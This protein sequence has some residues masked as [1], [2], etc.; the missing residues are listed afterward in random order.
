MH[1]QSRYTHESRQALTYAREEA[2]RLHHKN[3]GV[4]HLFLGLLR[5]HDPLIE[6]L[7]MSLHVN[8]EQLFQAVEF[9]LG[10]GNKALL[11]SP[12]LN[13]ATRSALSRA[14]DKA[15]VEQS[16]LTD[17]DHLLYGILSERGIISGVVESFGLTLSSIQRQIVYL[18]QGDQTQIMLTAHYQ[19]RYAITP[20]LNAVSRDLTILALEGTLDP[21]IGREAELERTMQVLSRRT[22]NNPVLLG[23]AGVGKTA[24]AEGLAQRIIADYVPETLHQM[25]VVALNIGMLTAGTKFRGEFEERLKH[26]VQE[27][28]A[29]KDIIIVL[30]D[31]H[32]L[33]KAGVAEGSV[34]A[35]NV[36]KPMLARGDFR[37]IGTTTIDDY[38]TT[39]E[40]DPALERRFQPIYVQEPSAQET[41]TMLRGLRHR[42]A[43]FHHVTI[44]DQVLAATV[45]LATRYLAGRYLPDKA[46]DLIDEAAVRVRIHHNIDSATIGHL[47]EQL[48]ITHYEK[49]RAIAQRDF[50]T[51]A[52]KR[53]QEREQTNAL[54]QAIQVWQEQIRPQPALSIQDIAA[55]ITD[56]TGI[57]VSCNEPE[58]RER[59]LHLE[60]ELHR[61]V[62]GQD[63]AI[64]AVARAVRRARTNI[65]DSHRPIGSFIFV[66]PNGVGKTEL[67]RTLAATLFGNENALLHL[68]MSEFMEHH[69]VSRLIGSPP[70]YIG[71]EQSGQLT[72]AVL[73]QPYRVILFDEIEK[74]HPQIFDLLL[75]I[76]EDGYLTD[77]H[78]QVVDFRHTIIILTSNIG[79]TTS[80]QQPMTFYRHTLS[81]QNA[82]GDRQRIQQQEQAM[83]IT[84]VKTFFKPELINRL[85]EIIVFHPL[86][87][88]QVCAIVDLLVAQT[89]QRLQEQSI[90]LDISPDA[91]QLLAER[92]YDGAYGA[93]ALRRTVQHLLNDPLAEAILRGDLCDATSIYVHVNKREDRQELMIAIHTHE[94]IILLF[95][96]DGTQDAA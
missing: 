10:Q 34:D 38:R 51:A 73:R 28:Y 89:K 68:D 24:I 94:E 22:K 54:E 26:I 19:A 48:T 17:V 53:M 57:P 5:L 56:W 82:N 23:P 47:R 27:I 84:T 49:E 70:G 42:Y 96:S 93:R 60:K 3:I 21:C 15:Q 79:T 66:G 11:G 7:F 20:T 91:R 4:G 76:F 16:D 64:Q 25:R 37:C 14:E 30:D 71:H 46:I 18:K 50:A 59:L 75:Q 95:E 8:I 13:A 45:Q 9:V 88:E 39:I 1:R 31:L 2:I 44:D 81:P 78:G 35:A 83:L 74:A 12:T 36:F 87:H 62:I 80:G 85:D 86:E 92:G 29:A 55:V 41:L 63:A 61:R 6:S 33:S 77:A 65:R 72:A 69:Q 32:I 58:E 67:A 52:Y 40:A 43:N 90:S